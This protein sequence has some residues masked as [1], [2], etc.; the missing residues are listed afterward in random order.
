MRQPGPG[1]PRLPSSPVRPG[2]SK[3]HELPGGRRRPVDFAT[4]LRAI[5]TIVSRRVRCLHWC[6]ETVRV[7]TGYGYEAFPEANPAEHAVKSNRVRR[8]DGRRERSFPPEVVLLADTKRDRDRPGQRGSFPDPK[9]ESEA[10]P[11]WAT[12]DRKNHRAT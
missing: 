12:R 11:R 8:R 5:R 7:R 1:V 3:I 10:P 9:G 4:G 6:E 2:G